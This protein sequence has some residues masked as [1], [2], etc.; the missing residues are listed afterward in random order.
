MRVLAVKPS[1][2]GSIVY[3]EDGRLVFSLEAEKNSFRRHADISAQLVDEALSLAPAPPD[4][5]AI[6]G[7]HKYLYGSTSKI[8]AGYRGTEPGVLERGQFLGRNI[9]RYTSSH[10]RSHVIGGVAMSP[11]A[12][13]S[14]IAVLVWEGTIGSLYRWRGRSNGLEVHPVLDQPGARY[15]ALFGI[16]DPSFADQGQFPPTEYAGKVMALAGCADGVPPSQDSLNVVDALMR[17]KAL[18]PFTKGYFRQAEIYN[19]GVE[20]TE[21]AR[22]ACHL[23]SRLFEHFFDAAQRVFEPGL[24]LVVAGGC[25][26]NCDWNSAWRSSGHFRDVFVPPCPDDTG[27][28]IGTAQD[29]IIQLGGPVALDWDVYSGSDFVVDTAAQAW[30]W[31]ERA[32]D[33][34]SVATVLATGSV[35]AWVQGRCEIG[36]RAL[37]HRSLL[38]SA[39]D[40]LMKDELNRI[41]EREPYRPIAPICL[42][43]DLAKWFDDATPDPYM[44]YF[45]HV[46]QPSSLPSVTHTND[47]ARVQSV[48]PKSGR[49]V[50]DLLVEHR[51][52]TG[53]GVLCNTSLNYPG[54]GFINQLS[55]LFTYCERVNVGWAVVNDKLYSSPEVSG[56]APT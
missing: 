48:T 1:H 54:R 14:D 26:L 32:L 17:K 42:E 10:E 52:L 16:A 50:Y 38:A 56:T 7:W 29:A 49:R 9:W 31:S 28:A 43:E 44:L 6:G 21:F 40:P 23:S 4:V 39:S 55:D 11:F 27:S 12:D 33:L 30:G 46:L 20:T 53:I 22:T 24:P 2:D 41:K 5:F 18:Y 51:R 13:E 34:R 37:G 25:G 8:A 36:P 19:A 45:R 15:S 3:I 35:V 47:T